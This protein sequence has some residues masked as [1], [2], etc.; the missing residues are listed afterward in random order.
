[1]KRSELIN[2]IL[3]VKEQTDLTTYPRSI[4]SVNT[5]LKNKDVKERLAKGKGYYYFV[6]G[7][8]YGWETSAVSVNSVNELSLNQWWDEYTTLKKNG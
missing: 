7:E 6:N 4:A 5:M 1:M 8:S 3:E 2:L